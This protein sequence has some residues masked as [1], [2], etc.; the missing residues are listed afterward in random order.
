MRTYCCGRPL[1]DALKSCAI[2]DLFFDNIQ[3]AMIVICFFF[4]DFLPEEYYQHRVPSVPNLT[5]NNG[6]VPSVYKPQE[7]PINAPQEEQDFRLYL[8]G[9]GF[10]IC[11]GSTISLFYWLWTGAKE[12]DMTKCRRWFCVRLVFL[13]FLII[14]TIYK[15]ST[16]NYYAFDAMF[17]IMKIYSIYEICLVKSFIDLQHI[18]TPILMKDRTTNSTTTTATNTTA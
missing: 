1:Q 12:G 6:T 4:P 17:E 10:L 2:L 8:A 5:R 14:V 18:D 13:T 7:N 15:L 9:L 3:V 16:H 11:F